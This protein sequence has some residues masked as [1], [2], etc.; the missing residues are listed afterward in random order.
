VSSGSIR[1]S[2]EDSRNIDRGELLWSVSCR[3][4]GRPTSPTNS[5][6]PV[7]TTAGRSGW[8]RSFIRMQ[9]L[10]RVCPGVLQEP[11]AALSELNLV[12]VP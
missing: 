12:S 3:E 8:P 2:H 11:E 6:S 1:S 4:V 5:V 9:M 7:K 10:S